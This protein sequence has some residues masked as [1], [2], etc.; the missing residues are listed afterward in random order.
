MCGL[1]FFE[2]NTFCKLVLVFSRARWGFHHVSFTLIRMA[3]AKLFFTL[4]CEMGFP[5]SCLL[6]WSYFYVV[7]GTKPLG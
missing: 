6:N 3:K 2:R 1:Y 7:K 4:T 5:P